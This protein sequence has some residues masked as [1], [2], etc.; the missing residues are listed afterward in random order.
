MMSPALAAPRKGETPM[1]KATAK[2]IMNDYAFPTEGKS[3]MG[4]IEDRPILAKSMD[5]TVTD[6][7]G[8]EYI[9]FQS[10]QMGAALGHQHPRIV[11]RI[12]ETL[13]TMMHS[14][15]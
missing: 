8:K 12:T 3:Y 10:G 14:S 6:I 5:R 7:D 2:K 13:K 9:D 11:K 15:N 1:E 4:G